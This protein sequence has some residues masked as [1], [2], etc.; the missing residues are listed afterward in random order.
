MRID[1]HGRS[2]SVAAQCVR[3]RLRI[4]MRMARG[5]PIHLHRRGG[6]PEHAAPKQQRK[7]QQGSRNTAVAVAVA[8]SGLAGIARTR[9]RVRAPVISTTH[10]FERPASLELHPSLKQES[11]L[12]SERVRRTSRD[13]AGRRFDVPARGI[14][15]SK[16]AGCAEP[17]PTRRGTRDT[18]QVPR[19]P[20]LGDVRRMWCA[21]G[22]VS[23]FFVAPP[24]TCVTPA[25]LTRPS[26]PA[27]RPALSP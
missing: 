7:S 27:G 18:G 16:R 24:H 9:T 5:V 12:R 21:A 19:R 1:S 14:T 6:P 3:E 10:Q 13:V 26:D 22:P 25:R 11:G 2:L 8:V 4:A 23:S 20:T 17:T 15:R